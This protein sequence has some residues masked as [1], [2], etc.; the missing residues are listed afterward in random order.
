MSHRF[1]ALA[2]AL[3]ACGSD[4]VSY[5]APVGINLK[6]KSSDAANGAVSNEK[7]ITTEQGNPYG[8]FVADARTKLGRDPG[9]IDVDRVEVLLGAGST[10]VTVLGDVFDGNFEVLFQMNDSA[11]S[12]PVANGLISDTGSAVTGSGV[13]L[14][15]NFA[16]DSVP[17]VDYQAMLSGSFKTVGRGPVSAGFVG[18][19][20]DVD[21]QLTFTFAAFE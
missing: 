21:L 14:S 2:F 16:A 3:A 1:I 15:A 5:S 7:A 9:V 20:A 6:L 17:D 8:A 10:G 13:T 18:K 11:N 12:Y 4:P 19:G